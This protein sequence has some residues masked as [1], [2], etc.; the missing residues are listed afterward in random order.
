[1]LRHVDGHIQ[2]PHPLIS[3]Y[4]KH[5]KDIYKLLLIQGECLLHLAILG[6]ML[7]YT[8]LYYILWPMSVHCFL[9]RYFQIC[10]IYPFLAMHVLQ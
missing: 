5:V 8:R 4:N 3:A 10:V 6:C 2:F 9:Y 1:M 7:F